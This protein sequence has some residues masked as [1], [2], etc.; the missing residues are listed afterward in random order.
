MSLVICDGKYLVSNGKMICSF[1]SIPM[2]FTTLIKIAETP[3]FIR[4]PYFQNLFL[5][6]T[7]TLGVKWGDGS[8]ETLDLDGEG[9]SIYP[10]HDFSEGIGTG[11]IKF[12]DFSN[13]TDFSFEE[14]Y[15][16]SEIDIF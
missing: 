3:S 12:G 16:I 8:E 11:I 14:V 10:Y 2:E 7:G 5:A 15:G 4:E 13:I 9:E 1:S 6:G